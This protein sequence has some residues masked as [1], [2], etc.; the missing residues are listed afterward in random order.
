MV[1]DSDEMAILANQWDID[2]GIVDTL[3]SNPYR[4]G[5]PIYLLKT[6][7]DNDFEV[8]SGT[9][10]YIKSQKCIQYKKFVDLKRKR[11]VDDSIY[12]VNKHQTD[13][14]LEELQD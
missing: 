6:K 9:K 10:E 13:K 7:L 14:D 2:N 5:K 12:Y 3:I 8:I 1:E 11:E 4:S